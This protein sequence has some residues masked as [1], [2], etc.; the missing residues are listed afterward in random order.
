MVL[1]VVSFSD[2]IFGL[3]EV[4]GGAVVAG[5]CSGVLAPI[6]A[7]VRLWVVVARGEGF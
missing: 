7:V 4:G 2:L 3:V 6:L 5:G 1:M